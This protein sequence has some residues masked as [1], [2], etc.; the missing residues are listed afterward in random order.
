MVLLRWGVTLVVAA[1]ALV[2]CVQQPKGPVNEPGCPSSHVVFARGSG[3]TVGAAE[4]KRFAQQVLPVFPNDPQTTFFE[5]GSDGSSVFQYPAAPID[6][7]LNMSSNAPVS[8]VGALR[9]FQSVAIGVSELKEY[10]AGFGARCPSSVLVLG[11]YSQGAH[12]VGEALSQLGAEGSRVLGQVKAVTFFG[13]PR[14]SLPE[15]TPQ[16]SGFVPACRGVEFSPWRVGVRNCRTHE[17]LLGARAEYVPKELVNRAASWCRPADVVC[18]ATRD[19][20]SWADHFTYAAPDGP[21]DQAARWIGQKV[22]GKEPAQGVGFALDRYYGALGAP[23]SFAVSGVGAGEFQ[24]DV[25]GDG[26]PDVTGKDGVFVYEF[27]EFFDSFVTVTTPQGVAS[28]PVTAT[29]LPVWQKA[30]LPAVDVRVSRSVRAATVQWGA[31]DPLTLGWVVWVDHFPVGVVLGAPSPTS[32]TG[33]DP[34]REYRIG[35]S[36][37]QLDGSYGPVVEA[38]APRPAK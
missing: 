18:G 17:G 19:V 38:I 2:G 6:R 22:L 36:P 25:D 5:L 29:T 20:R 21:I 28:V 4:A 9:Y 37:V 24:V 26:S 14:L 23:V 30:P 13:D 3:Q 7:S 31:Q 32:V 35:V 11:G 33:L 27:S 16:G 8:A 15:G 10:L 34:E 12:V 1:S